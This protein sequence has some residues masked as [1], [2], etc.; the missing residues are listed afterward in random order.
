M[1]RTV[2]EQEVPVDQIYKLS[3]EHTW[4]LDF[5]NREPVKIVSLDAIK[6]KSDFWIYANEAQLSE[7]Q[8][9]GFDW[10]RQYTEAQFRITRLQKKFLD[11]STR[12][13]SAT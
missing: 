10:D 5:Y 1:A 8:Q 6:N 3:T 13:K 7:L 12:K 9:A 4:A 2:K 11:P